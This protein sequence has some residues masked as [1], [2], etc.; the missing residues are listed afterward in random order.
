MWGTDLIKL[1]LTCQLLKEVTT[2]TRKLETS[3]NPEPFLGRLTP[4]LG[5]K[6]TKIRELYTIC[7]VKSKK[8]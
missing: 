8:T 7:R 3:S 2:Y 6:C 4:I 1:F 5:S